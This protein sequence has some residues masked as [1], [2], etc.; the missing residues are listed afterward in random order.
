MSVD[1]MLNSTLETVLPDACFP[2]AYTGNLL[3]YAVWAYT[4]IPTV[5]AD[6]APHAARYLIQVHYYLPHK[7]NPNAI[8]RQLQRALFAAGCT[9]PS[10][11]NASDADC[12]HYV[13]ECEWTD[14]G[15]YYGQ[16]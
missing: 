7:I 5:F 12:Q 15:G 14:G 2:N 10:V 9:W 6:R 13:F 3:E 16:S 1:S 11:T 4:E 8:K